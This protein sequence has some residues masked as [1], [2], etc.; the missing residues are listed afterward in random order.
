MFNTV[1]V[2][3][4]GEEDEISIKD[5]ANMIVEAMNYTGAVVVSFN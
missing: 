3:P 2:M 4:V 1:L 5:G